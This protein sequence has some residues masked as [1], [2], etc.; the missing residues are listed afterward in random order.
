MVAIKSWLGILN[1]EDLLRPTNQ[2]DHLLADVEKR[3]VNTKSYS[4]LFKESL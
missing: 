2:Q 3:I 4:T 1:N